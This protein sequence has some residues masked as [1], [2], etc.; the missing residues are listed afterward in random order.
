MTPSGV[1]EQGK[2]SLSDG[3]SIYYNMDESSFTRSIQVTPL[4]AHR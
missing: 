4:T 3:V 2:D 1:S